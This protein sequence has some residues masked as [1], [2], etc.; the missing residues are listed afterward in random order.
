MASNEDTA[1]AQSLAARP[2]SSAMNGKQTCALKTLVTDEVGEEFAKFARE[3][4][5]PSASDC[6]REL[7]M[8]SVYGP[9]YLSDL[10]RRRIASLGLN[11]SAI[12]TE[13]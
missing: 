6:L 3:R 7:V 8:V 1:Q 13:A 5:Y 10:H 9:D 12:G 4:G 2:T 11:R